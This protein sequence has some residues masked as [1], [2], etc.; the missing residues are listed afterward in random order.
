MKKYLKIPAYVWAFACLLLVPVTF[1]KNETLARGMAHLPF[2]KVHPKY[3]GGKI[4]RSYL[5]DG[6]HIT[7]FEPVYSGLRGRGKN[8]FV[9]VTFAGIKQMPD[10]I[11]ESIDYNMDGNADFT[12]KIN[13]RNGVTGISAINPVIKSLEVSSKVKSDWLIRVKVMRD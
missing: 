12:V 11:H 9:Q 2:M 3:S 6:L 13:T 1:I 4:N 7:V 10:S 5:T 8:G